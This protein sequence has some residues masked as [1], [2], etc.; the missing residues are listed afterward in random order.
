MF[1][2]GGVSLV[3]WQDWP[4]SCGGLSCSSSYSSSAG[5]QGKQVILGIQLIVAI[6]IMRARHGIEVIGA[7]Q[8][9]NNKEL[10]AHVSASLAL[11]H[12]ASR[13]RQARGIKHEAC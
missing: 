7:S 12:A 6:E 11:S 1:V 3:C 4:R 9:C 8:A 5:S 13:A 2:F 10:A